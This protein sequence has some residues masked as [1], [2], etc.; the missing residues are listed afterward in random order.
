M[1]QLDGNDPRVDD[2]VTAP[3]VEILAARALAILATRGAQ[4]SPRLVERLRFLADA[5]MAMDTDA[6]VEALERV[7]ADG[8]SIDDV[9]DHV[10]PEVARLAGKLWA[11]DDVS[12]V[13][14]S[15]ASAR[16]QESVRRLRRRE[17]GK[18]DVGGAEAN[19]LLIVPPSEE[20][21]LGIFVAADQLRRMGTSVEISIAERPRDIAGRLKAKTY[22]LVGITASG[23]RT[24]AYVKELIKTVRRH[25]K[26]FVPIALGGPII[27]NDGLGLDQLGVEFVSEDIR[28][29][30]QRCGL[31]LRETNATDEVV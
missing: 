8:V 17:R 27:L 28:L 25:T 29:T 7:L 5:F 26:A 3:E 18:M 12:F 22:K 31:A 4:Q 9:I 14:V 6:S 24:L 19:V 13:D 11:E 2:P 15:I 16:L 1:I 20:H 30:A 21:T 10:I 23:P